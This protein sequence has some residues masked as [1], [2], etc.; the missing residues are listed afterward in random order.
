MAN[1]N[2]HIADLND[3]RIKGYVNRGYGMLPDGVTK[4]RKGIDFENFYE[5]PGY[6]PMYGLD[7]K[8][9]VAGEGI[10]LGD[11]KSFEVVIAIYD[12][13]G[14]EIDVSEAHQKIAYVSENSLDGYSESDI[15]PSGNYKQIGSG[16]STKFDLTIYTGYASDGVTLTESSVEDGA[17]FNIQLLNGDIV[18]LC[19]LRISHLQFNLTEDAEMGAPVAAPTSAPVA[20]VKK[21]QIT[22]DNKLIADLAD[23]NIKAYVNNGD[24]VTEKGIEKSSYAITFAVTRGNEKVLYPMF[25]L[26]FGD[27]L[28]VNDIKIEDVKCFDIVAVPLNA[29]GDEIPMK[30]EFQK[31]AFVSRAALNG[32]SQ[33]DILVTG[34]YKEIGSEMQTTFDLTKYDASKIGTSRQVVSKLEDGVGF[35]L[36]VLNGDYMNMQYLIVSSLVFTLK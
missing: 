11:I 24:G 25:A 18:D 9:Y 32:Y 30:D 7:F 1:Q 26:D 14:K 13:T 17:G 35:N 31:C 36:Q 29:D 21:A 27:Y 33:S 23:P 10:D 16:I 22:E 15:L 19:N 5:G 20:P 4:S 6:Y 2:V 12:E 34:N 28:A 3:P 8:E